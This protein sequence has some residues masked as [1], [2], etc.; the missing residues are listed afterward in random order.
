MGWFILLGLLVA[1]WGALGTYAVIQ[2]VS[3]WEE[4]RD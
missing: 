3:I 4:P 2:A 1:A